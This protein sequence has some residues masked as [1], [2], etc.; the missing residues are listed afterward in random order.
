M[1][2]RKALALL[3][4]AGAIAAVADL[5][6]FKPLV[7]VGISSFEPQKSIHGVKTL[8][9]SWSPDGEVRYLVGF[10]FDAIPR[11]AVIN[12]ANLTFRV[13]G[14]S[15]PLKLE[16]WSVQGT[17]DVVCTSWIMMTCEKAWP[18][19]GGVMKELVDEKYV[20]LSGPGELTFNVTSFVQDLVI[21]GKEGWLLLRVGNET[22]WVLVDT[23]ISSNPP[24]VTVAYRKPVLVAHS[25][26]KEVRI[27]QGEMVRFKV[28]VE[29]S[30]PVPVKLE[31][32]SPIPL[33]YS[34][35]PE[36]GLPPFNSTLSIKVPSNSP[37]GD[38]KLLVRAE[39]PT[40]ELS[41]NFTLDFTVLEAVG[42]EVEG[43]SQL[44]L[45]G[46]EVEEVGLSV[47]PKGGYSEKV[48]ITIKEAP[49]WLFILLE[50]NLG[51]PPF[52]A[53]MKLKPLPNANGTG[54]IVLQFSGQG[55]LK[56]VTINVTASPR[57]V[58]VYANWIDWNL[59]KG[60]LTSG[61]NETGIQ[62]NRLREPNFSGYDLVILLGGPLAPT[63]D[64]MP[65]NLVSKI[66]PEAI[67]QEL[68]DKGW[69]VYWSEYKGVKVVVV[70]GKD[71]Y[72]TSKLLKMDLDGDGVPLYLELM[73][74]TAGD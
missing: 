44:S 42:I 67:V 24:T 18:V 72:I 36:E 37:P 40:P 51:E 55:V 14:I 62:L 47:L 31:L 3:L 71:R 6:T 15:S 33:N 61:A 46:G 58:A 43:P 8:N 16:L 50:P 19:E 41:S 59:S 4:L 34:F 73:R 9:V 52:N 65:E 66:L 22:G 29:G 60:I 74:G 64:W 63:D 28:M 17:P 10:S 13:E 12:S 69:I 1:P 35:D 32:E 5:N 30:L 54:K 53:T 2:V 39:G 38:Y 48:F 20:E 7:D 26:V 68:L 45:K 27:S 11:Y 57:R 21:E 56:D 49:E 23:E 25:K 70:A